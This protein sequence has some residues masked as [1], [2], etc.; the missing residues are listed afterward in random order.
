ME[1]KKN[2]Y[3]LA[4]FDV[5]G[6]QD[7]IFATNRLREN[8]GASYQV[9]RIMEEFL[10]ESFQEAAAR[11]NVKVILDW[12]HEAQLLLPQDEEIMAEIIY[13]GGGNGVAL[14]RNLEFFC[15]VGEKLGIKAAIK[16]QGIYLAAAYI[17]T[18]L[19]DFA[20]DRRRLDQEMNEKKHHMIRQPIYSPFPVVE[21]EDGSHQPI[22]DR[23][24]Y[25]AESENVTRVQFQKR[26]AYKDIIHYKRLFPELKNGVSYGYPEEMDQLSREYGEDSMVAVVH[27]DGNGMGDRIN[28]LLGEHVGYVEGVPILRRESQKI[29]ELFEDTYHEVLQELWD[30]QILVNENRTEEEKGVFPLRPI[31][32]DGD[33]FTFICRAELAVPTAAGFMMRLLQKQSDEAKKITACGGIAFVHSHFPFRVAYSIA[34]KSCGQAKNAWYDEKGQRESAMSVCFLDFQVIKDSEVGFS[35]KHSSYQ[36]RPYSIG[37]D[38]E[39]ARE[40]SLEALCDVLAK[41]EE[42]WPSGRLHKIYRAFLEG[43]HAMEF[44]N[45]EFI[46]RGYNINSLVSGKWED[47]PLYDA[48]DLQGMCRLDLVKKFLK[49]Q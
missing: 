18:D 9:T 11:E 30:C 7:Y 48:L 22:T 15:R 25:E 19:S 35:F 2:N 13:I 43:N 20:A 1:N 8:A 16:C 42:E 34:E 28:G 36:K 3:I 5:G 38:G 32:M 10:P 41:M 45:K 23:I 31:L 21:Q 17:E 27:I 6:I 47:S 29:A 24:C 12:K 46:S 14:F 44:L 33:D 39:M 26:N 49:I 40:R 37:I 4:K